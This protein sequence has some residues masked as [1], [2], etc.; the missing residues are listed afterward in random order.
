M[1]WLVDP[2][3]TFDQHNPLKDDARRFAGVTLRGKPCV[4]ID[5]TGNSLPEAELVV[6]L[7]SLIEG[8]QF[9]F[10]PR[11]SGG[12]SA[13]A[14]ARRESTHIQVGDKLYRLIIYRFEARIENF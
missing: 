9:G 6:I 11:S 1:G 2:E 8:D 4:L 5:N 7:K 12:G 13:L 14:L 10:K 3:D